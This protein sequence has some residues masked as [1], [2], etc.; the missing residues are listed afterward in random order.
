MNKVSV[1]QA[2]LGNS[3]ITVETGKLA[4]LAGG[5][6]TVRYGDTMILA[7][8]TSA[9]TPREAADFFPLTVDYE[10]RLYAAGKIPG[11]F[12]KRE[13]RPTEAAILLCRLVDRSIR[14]LF[15]KG[16]RNDVQVVVTALSADQEHYLD[17]LS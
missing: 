3:T 5:A 2:Q 1:F 16:M 10:E 14:P 9:A 13:G 8:A 11:G 6:V 4:G 15:P 12:F 7:T 17:I